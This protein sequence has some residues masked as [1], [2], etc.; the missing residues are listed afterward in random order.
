[1]SPRGQ[2]VVRPA[3]GDEWRRLGHL[4]GDAFQDDP[5]WQWVVLDPQRRRRHLGAAFAQLIRSSA[6]AGNL[7]TTEDLAG[8][9]MWA[10]PG[11]WRT[12]PSELARMALPMARAVGLRHARDRS[13][14]LAAMDEH[15]PSEPHWYLA[16]LGADA[17]R[18]GQG[19]GAA[20][21]APMIE[22][23]DAEG[24][25]AY[26]ESSKEQNLAFYHRFGFE[27]SGEFRLAPDSP[28]LWPMW[29]HPR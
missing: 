8:A 12:T 23:C 7:W 13:R 1:M 18:R 29:R 25:P 27:V 10:A 26:L 4:L 14:A 2:H 15:H 9:A 20:L 21:M 5:V 19:I 11:R 6:A 16:I 17:S 22:R 3:V 28:P 24:V